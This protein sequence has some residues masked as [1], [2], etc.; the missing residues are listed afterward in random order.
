M[1]QILLPGQVSSIIFGFFVILAVASRP[2]AAATD[3]PALAPTTANPTIQIY[4]SLD[5]NVSKPL[6]AA[7]QQN[8][9]G[10]AV[11]YFDLQSLDIGAAAGET[12]DATIS[13]DMRDT[14]LRSQLAPDAKITTNR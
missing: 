2:V 9:P 4:S 10:I 3:F 6:I 14:I 12:H 1:K 11:R 13:I 8:N 7:Y 5:E